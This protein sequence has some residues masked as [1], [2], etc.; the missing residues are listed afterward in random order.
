M[1]TEFDTAFAE[2][3]TETGIG[4]LVMDRPESLNALNQQLQTDIIAGLD[5]LKTHEETA[6]AKGLRVIILEGSGD[7]FCAGADITEFDDPAP[8]W[9]LKDHYEAIMDYPAPVIAKIHG[10]CLGGGLET[11]MA[12]DFR[13]AHESSRL[14]LPEVDI[15]ILP[16]AGG[17]QFISHVA[18]PAAA[19]EIAM[20][21]EPIDADRAH[22]L[23]LVHRTYED[24][25][26][27]DVEGFA[28]KLAGKPP[29]ALRAIKRSVDM[30]TQM[31]IREARKHDLSQAAYLL[32]TED[33]DEGVK[34]FL[35]DGYDP[36][37]RGR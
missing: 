22:E 10:N 1:R 26:A 19:K 29:L 16:G 31:G 18:S 5:W 2:F 14:G 15:G 20:T 21:G 36:T 32:S 33:A 23:G 35:E 11:A 17:I 25:T 12:C 13:F 27:E 34:A 24:S 3:D 9:G 28:K 7:S 4:H 6:D 37:F 30:T 8:P